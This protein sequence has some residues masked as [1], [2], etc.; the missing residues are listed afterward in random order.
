[1][2]VIVQ[3]IFAGIYWLAM[4]FVTLI[5]NAF[6]AI[7]NLIIA[8]INGLVHALI[9][10]LPDWLEKYFEWTEIP[11]LNYL[12]TSDIP[13]SIYQVLEDLG[14]SW[15]AVTVS[16]NEYWWGVQEHAPWS[17]AAGA[18]AGAAT[19]IVGYVTPPGSSRGG[20]SKSGKYVVRK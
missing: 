8:A 10:W 15:N 9:S 19:T 6:I 11:L 2:V 3:I 13:S 7:A 12:S 17:Y 1:M 16:I 18:A 5:A 14:L 20:G 4:N